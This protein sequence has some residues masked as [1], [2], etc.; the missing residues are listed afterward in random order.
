KSDFGKGE[1]GGGGRDFDKDGPKGGGKGDFGKDGSKGGGRGGSSLAGWMLE[2][3]QDLCDKFQ[4]DDRLQRRLTERMESREDTFK[5]DMR[6]LTETLE[7][8]RNPPG[9]LSV[10]MREMEDGTF[11]PKGGGKGD[12]GKGKSFNSRL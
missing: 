9:L 10:K 5:E 4:I 3:I 7:T 6:S 11:V 2:D 12:R 1:F 8:A